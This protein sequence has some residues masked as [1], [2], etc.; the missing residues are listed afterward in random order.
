MT[1]L[2]ALRLRANSHRPRQ[3]W[4]QVG[5]HSFS[6]QIL[7]RT[8]PRRP[9]DLRVLRMVILP[10]ASTEPV[11]RD[12]FF[13]RPD[14]SR[15]TAVVA[16]SVPLAGRRIG[17]GLPPALA[18]TAHSACRGRFRTTAARVETRNPALSDGAARFERGTMCWCP[19]TPDRL[20]AD[21]CSV[22]FCA[23]RVSRRASC[24]R[25]SSTSS[26]TSL[27]GGDRSGTR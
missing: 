6:D 18:W 1:P 15:A 19:A 13:A 2:Q 17:A 24:G 10:P 4:W 21:C 9:C 22:E 25:R 20:Q 26:H 12:R 16:Q 23:L 5:A 27:S 7:E 8:R 3:G 14:L 11:L